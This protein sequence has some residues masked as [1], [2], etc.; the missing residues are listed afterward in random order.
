MQRGGTALVIVWGYKRSFTMY[1]LR[2]FWGSAGTIHPLPKTCRLHFF[3]AVMDLVAVELILDD[4]R[5]L[6]KYRSDIINGRIIAAPDEE[7]DCVTH[8]WWRLAD[9]RKEFDRA[10][11]QK[12]I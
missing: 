11:K 6:A 9:L 7:D 2:T 10:K 8:I 4:L 12:E 1:S 3:A 5:R